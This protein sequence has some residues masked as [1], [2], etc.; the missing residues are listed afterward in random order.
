MGA[1]RE[2]V[3]GTVRGYIRGCRCDPCKT[4]HAEQMRHDREVRGE[5]VRQ[6][7]P[8]VPHGTNSG[9]FNWGCRCDPCKAQ[10]VI[11]NARR[12]QRRS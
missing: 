12:R 5:L 2:I 10:G 8:R 6:G 1:T 4:V 7:D 9:Y 11:G 3:H